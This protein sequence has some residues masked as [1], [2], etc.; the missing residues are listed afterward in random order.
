[1]LS[2]L[3]NQRAYIEG[4]WMVEAHDATR[5][6]AVTI[7]GPDPNIRLVLDASRLTIARRLQLA[8]KI[9]EIIT[10]AERAGEIFT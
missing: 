10:E 6:D 7:V 5:F 4:T 2:A 9:A 1:M 3:N 8:E